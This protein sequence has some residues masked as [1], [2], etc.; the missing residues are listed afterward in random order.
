MFAVVDGA[1]RQLIVAE[2]GMPGALP[3]RLRSKEGALKN[4]P[5]SATLESLANEIGASATIEIWRPSFDADEDLV[6]WSL[7]TT[8]GD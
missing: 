3:D 5:L 7:L 1:D 6:T 8:S 2:D 4:A